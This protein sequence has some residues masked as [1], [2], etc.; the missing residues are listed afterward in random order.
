MRPGLFRRPLEALDLRA[1]RQGGRD[2]KRPVRLPDD[3]AER[4]VVSKI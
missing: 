3:G 1:Q 4:R 2:D